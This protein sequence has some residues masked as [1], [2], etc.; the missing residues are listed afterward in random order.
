MLP[1]LGERGFGA[2]EGVSA[3]EVPIEDL[4]RFWADPL[5]YTPPGAEP[6]SAFRERVRGG[7]QA[8]LHGDARHPLVVTHG[9]VVRVIIGEVLGLAA[10]ALLLIEV[11]PACR[12]RLRL[13]VGGGRPSLISH[14]QDPAPR[15]A[16]AC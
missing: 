2:W 11:P 6:F 13:P 14:G 15:R 4:S 7:W 3:D 1:A 9:G 10:E 12:T 16:A 8:V 5:G